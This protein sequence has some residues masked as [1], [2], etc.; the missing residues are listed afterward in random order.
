MKI[1]SIFGFAA[2]AV[3][4]FAAA[5]CSD[6][7]TGDFSSEVTFRDGD[8]TFACEAAGGE[9]TLAFFSKCGHWE[10]A[11]PEEAAGWVSVWPA[12]GDDNGKTT[13]T[14][15]E[16][17]SA[18]ARRA[19]L[20]IVTARGV[21]GQIVVSQ[22]GTAPYIDLD[23]SAGYIRADIVGTP[24][25]VA[26]ASNVRWEATI[27][28]GGEWISLGE[29]SET[30]QQFLF[31]DNTGQPKREGKVRF[32]MVDGDYSVPVRV[33]QLD[34]NTS[35][36]TS[37]PVSIADLLGEV[38]LA[39]GR[40]EIEDN[41]AVYGW[42]T[43]DLTRKNMPDS[44]LYVQDAGGR[45]LKLLLKDKNE[46]LTPAVEREGWYA[47]GRKVALHMYALEF[48]EDAE[49]NLAIVDFPATAIKSSV[50]EAAPAGL[51]V[52]LPDLATLAD[53]GN[54]LVTVDPVEFVFP[55]GCYTN[56][57]ENSPLADIEA[58]WAK[59]NEVQKRYRAAFA[60]FH[61]FPQLVRDRRGNVAK[62]W[63]T[64]EFTEAFSK[65]LPQ[66]SGPLT[67]IVSKFRGEYVLQMRS[68]ADDGLDASSASRKSV[69]LLKTGPWRDNTVTVPAFEKGNEAGDASSIVFSLKNGSG[70]DNVE[71]SGQP[72]GMYWL[73]APFRTDCLTPWTAEQTDRYLALN[74]KWW[75]SGANSILSNTTDLGEGFVLR[76]NV[77]RHATGDLWLAF[78]T[79]S[80]KGGPG[81]LKIQWA[82]TTSADLSKVTFNDIA[83]YNSPVVDYHPFQMPYSF[84]LP[85]EMKGKA[86][87]VIVF[88]CADGSDNARKLD[89]PAKVGDTGTNRLGSIEIV[90]IK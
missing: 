15:E 76:T 60:D 88:R 67:G 47:A 41:Y 79:T 35:F 56:Y 36:E 90:E 81:A 17:T 33:A 75:W 9:K 28:E 45:G 10:L 31:E 68:A 71:S 12:Y 32:S 64:S 46:V 74:A 53:F 38:R 80:S 49:G 84:K 72:T 52:P 20:N 14:V 89:S 85:A 30:T 51:A 54:T 82:E 63:F 87:V 24:V 37:T 21:V 70:N 2:L 43:S 69:T 58:T 26:V 73:D 57:F 16:L 5:G 25:T 1:F 78:T 42:I 3:A 44:V 23:L 8:G 7:N 59:K 19:T 11:V 65:N 55:Y 39:D 6:D 22:N 48:R 50:D 18:Y 86:D 77:L 66:G 4:A 13:I 61:L 62:L 29:T 27:E 40:Y 34:G 83:T